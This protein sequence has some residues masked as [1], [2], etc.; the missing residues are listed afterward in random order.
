MS[1]G[2]VRCQDMGRTPTLWKDRRGPSC[3]G[4]TVTPTLCRHRENHQALGRQEDSHPLATHGTH[5]QDIDDHLPQGTDKG[6]MITTLWGQ[7]WGPLH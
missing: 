4:D 6:E 5:S 2:Y 7:E 3:S 1:S